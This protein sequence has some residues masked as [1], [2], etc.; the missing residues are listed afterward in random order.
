MLFLKTSREL[1]N[2]LR[3]LHV[4]FPHS[5]SART[6]STIKQRIDLELYSLLLLRYGCVNSS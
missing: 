1:Q 3:F 4:L 6:T 5:I 2:I